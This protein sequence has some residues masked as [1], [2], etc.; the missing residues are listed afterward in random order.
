MV[1]P[2]TVYI[3]DYLTNGFSNEKRQNTM[4]HE[5]GHSLGLDH[6]GSLKYSP[7]TLM[8]Y[9]N[10]SFT[11]YT[12]FVPVLDDI[13]GVQARY[14]APGNTTQCY[15]FVSNGNVNY[16]GTCSVNGYAALPMTEYVTSAGSQNRA[17]A[18]HYSTSRVLPAVGT[19]LMTTD[20]QIPNL[21]K[22]YRFSLGVHT[23]NNV[24]NPASRFS[25]IDLDND[26]IKAVYDDS[27]GNSQV[28]IMNNTSPN[29]ADYFLEV[30]FENGKPTSTYAYLNNNGGGTPPNFLGSTTFSPG[31]GWSSS[32]FYGTGV[33]TDNFLNP[34]SQYKVTKYI[35]RLLSWSPSG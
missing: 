5:L 20:V 12:I 26:G 10:I 21:S 9:T 15:T 33:W 19:A 11:N 16:T 4:A 2:T 22:A 7:E 8:Y 3:N 24:A 6:S 31:S 28:I 30:A 13:R 29:T 14:G 25:T 17:F 18:T 27:S 1:A 23:D 35:N 34:L 32:V